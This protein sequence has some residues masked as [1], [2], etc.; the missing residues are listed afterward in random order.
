[1]AVPVAQAQLDPVARQ[2]CHEQF[3]HE[4]ADRG[5]VFRMRQR[6]P[7]G[8]VRV[9]LARPVAKHRPPALGVVDF[10]R[11]EVVVPG[12][13]GGAPQ[14]QAQAFFGL[15]QALLGPLQGSAVRKAD[16]DPAQAP[17]V[18]PFRI[19]V[20]NQPAHRVASGRRHTDDQVGD[21]LAGSQDH[22]DRI[23]LR[24]HWGPV[25]AHEIPGAHAGFGALQLPCILP[26]QLAGK[27]VCGHDA[28]VGAVH[29]D[30]G[31][32]MLEQVVEAPLDVRGRTGFHRVHRYVWSGRPYPSTTRTAL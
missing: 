30:A 17:V 9:Q 27:P 25:G 4:C 7:Q 1:M 16:D 21:L 22:V 12:R 18:V 31:R 29:D 10:P 28:S 3:A 23:L 11:Y 6:Q 14:N 5:P 26:E 15:L 8:L 13:I 20:A 19:G 24:A 2:R 32:Q